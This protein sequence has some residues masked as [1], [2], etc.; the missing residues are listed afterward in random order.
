MDMGDLASDTP[1]GGPLLLVPVYYYNTATTCR[2]TILVLRPAVRY[3]ALFR[4]LWKTNLLRRLL[5]VSRRHWIS[6]M[7]VFSIFHSFLSSLQVQGRTALPE[8]F[9]S[10]ELRP[11]MNRKGYLIPSQKTRSQCTR[12]TRCPLRPHAHFR[13]G[14]IIQTVWAVGGRRCPRRH[15]RA[16]GRDRI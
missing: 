3:P 13:L 15:H 6:T 14:K 4:N 10:A 8:F 9:V 1:K 11:G 7:I 16:L 5:R 2:D 12:C